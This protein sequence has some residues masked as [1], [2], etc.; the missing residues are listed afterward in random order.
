MNNPLACVVFDVGR[1][2]SVPS[3][4]SPVRRT[5]YLYGTLNAANVCCRYMQKYRL[6]R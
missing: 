5:W 2:V 1:D 4:D 6:T 3:F